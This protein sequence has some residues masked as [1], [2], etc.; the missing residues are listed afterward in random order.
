MKKTAYILIGIAAVITVLSP[1]SLD[2]SPRYAKAQFEQSTTAS[3]PSTGTTVT[4]GVT[5]G[6]AVVTAPVPCGSGVLG[7]TDIFIRPIECGL[8]PGL[9]NSVLGLMSYFLEIAA[10]FLDAAMQFTLELSVRTQSLGIE[11]A[12][13]VVR[14]LLNIAFIFVILWI[15]IK[16]ILQL[17]DDR[18]LLGSIIISALLINFSLFFTKVIID[19]SNVMALQFYTGITG[20]NA[21]GTGLSDQFMERIKL[22]TVFGNPGTTTGLDFTSILAISVFGSIFILITAVVFFLAALMI[23]ARSVILIFLMVVSPIGFVGAWIPKLGEYA[24]KWWSNLINQSLVAPV[25]ML[26][27][28]MIL[29]MTENSGLNNLVGGNFTT[30]TA[31]FSSAIAGTGGSVGIIFYFALFITLII[32]A[33]KITTGLSGEIGGTATG[34]GKKALGAAVGGGLGALAFGG[35]QVLGSRFARLAESEGMQSWAKSSRVG[36]LALRATE[37]VAKSNFD[38]RN[39]PGAGEIGKTLKTAGVGLDLGK[40][41][42]GGYRSD[43]ERWAKAREAD[44][45]LFEKKETKEEEAQR[46]QTATEKKQK[47]DSLHR[48]DEAAAR[49]SY[50]DT[51]GKG[52]YDQEF[53]LN[54]KSTKQ[55]TASQQQSYAETLKKP[56]FKIGITPSMLAA[57]RQAA[58]KIKKSTEEL[59]RLEEDIKEL[60]ENIRNLIGSNEISVENIEKAIEAFEGQASQEKITSEDQTV[61]SSVRGEALAKKLSLERKIKKLETMPDQLDKKKEKLDKARGGDKKEEKKEEKPAG[62]GGEEKK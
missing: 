61:G 15:A 51:Y 42:T 18:K 7:F 28:W 46:I 48:G 16:T 13:K 53:V 62:G 21:P 44:K 24:G 20:G 45:K 25:F 5:T 59:G 14:D 57:E 9:A 22:S 23:L 29:K 54:T 6:S 2:A 39:M 4:T 56:A 27:V 26:F 32:T 50:D 36:M 34:W 58:G 3:S 52:A 19:T 47:F 8:L 40:A 35:R 30:A 31:S 10:R 41:Q 12:W 1:F 49:A 11:N 60:E 37:G 33:L 55:V 17:G 38:L 43:V